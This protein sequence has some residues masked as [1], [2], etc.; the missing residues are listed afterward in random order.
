VFTLSSC[1]NEDA[2]EFPE[3]VKGTFDFENVIN[4]T[5]LDGRP[6]FTGMK[7]SDLSKNFTLGDCYLDYEKQY[8]EYNRHSKVYHLLYKD[9]DIGGIELEND[10]NEVFFLRIEDKIP[11]EK[12]SICGINFKSTSNDVIETFGEP[13]YND[14]I[15]IYGDSEI[16][17]IYFWLY[18]S[19]T[20]QTV[21]IYIIGE[22][23]NE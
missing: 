20:V 1:Q 12:L 23:T 4:N 6:L 11:N 19:K 13:I 22:E 18:G 15:I 7:F 14:G 16:E 2:K 17:N 9:V 3:H 8:P 10:G 5:I 21:N